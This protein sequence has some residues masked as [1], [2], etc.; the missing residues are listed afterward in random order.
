METIS[1][2]WRCSEFMKTVVVKRWRCSNSIQIGVNIV[3]R[4]NKNKPNKS[5]I[6]LRTG[7]CKSVCV[8]RLPGM[9]YCMLS[10]SSRSRSPRKQMAADENKMAD[11]SA[12]PTPHHATMYDQSYHTRTFLINI[13]FIPVPFGGGMVVPGEWDHSYR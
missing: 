1:V 11:S 13:W 12:S 6:R 7:Q 10:A 2:R 3:D 9:R 8:K 4:L 5:P